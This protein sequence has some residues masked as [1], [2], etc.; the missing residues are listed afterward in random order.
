MYKPV[1]QLSATIT[2]QLYR[3]V[4]FVVL[5]SLLDIENSTGESSEVSNR[6]SLASIG[7]EVGLGSVLVK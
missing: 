3:V 2:T 7:S 5:V 6:H 4:Q 1:E